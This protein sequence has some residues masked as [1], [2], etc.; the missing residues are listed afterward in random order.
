MFFVPAGKGGKEE[1]ADERE[2]NGDDSEMDR[3]PSL[4]RRE[5]QEVILTLGTEIRYCP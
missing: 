3:Q 4:S 1:E 5:K 2:D